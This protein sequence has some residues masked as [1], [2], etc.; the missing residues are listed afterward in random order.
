MKGD[1]N[2]L[3]VN[4]RGDLVTKDREKSEVLNVFFILVFTGK[5]ALQESPVPKTN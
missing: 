4:A 2:G 1:E 3:L 5:T